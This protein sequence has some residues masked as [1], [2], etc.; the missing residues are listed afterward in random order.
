MNAFRDKPGIK[1][2]EGRLSLCSNAKRMASSLPSFLYS[3]VVNEDVCI[4]SVFEL[5][6]RHLPEMRLYLRMVHVFLYCTTKVIPLPTRLSWDIASADNP[7]K[8]AG[9]DPRSL[10][11]ESHDIRKGYYRV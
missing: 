5:S 11:W 3:S 8:T 2:H 6:R 7:R 4:L 1:A 9:I 10:E